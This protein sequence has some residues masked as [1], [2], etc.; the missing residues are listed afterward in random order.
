MYATNPDLT[1]IINDDK[2]LPIISQNQNKYVVDVYLNGNEKYKN[3]FN[4]S[5]IIKLDSELK[6]T[7][8]LILL[9]PAHPDEHKRVLRT[10]QYRTP[11]K[12][13]KEL[14]ERLQKSVCG[15]DNNTVQMAVASQSRLFRFRSLRGTGYIVWAARVNR[16]SPNSLKNTIA[17]DVPIFIGMDG[18]MNIINI[19]IL[20]V[21]D[22]FIVEKHGKYNMYPIALD[23]V[24]LETPI[25]TVLFPCEA[26]C[27][28]AKKKII[29]TISNKCADMK[30]RDLVARSFIQNLDSYD[31]PFEDEEDSEDSIILEDS[32][33]FASV[34]LVQ[35][36]PRAI[37]PDRLNL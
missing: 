4:N 16:E 11:A 5:Y 31:A 33:T 28:I 1:N 15:A 10:S 24:T 19:I 35:E 18:N 26:D 25:D 36:T 22:E 2:W 29:Q 23:K 12:L 34:D 37:I 3:I 6:K 20:P 30:T 32:G 27:R 9:F 21:Q 14:N 8:N 13:G 7:N 17:E